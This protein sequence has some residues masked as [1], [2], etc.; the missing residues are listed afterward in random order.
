MCIYKLCRK[1]LGPHYRVC[2]YTYIYIYTQQMWW[3]VW[4]IAVL[5]RK[6]RLTRKGLKGLGGPHIGCEG[7]VTFRKSRF[8][9]ALQ[10][11]FQ[12]W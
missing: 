9:E 1:G 10:N 2:V 12:R 5:W 6:V 11:C 7:E 8:P 4:Y 3:C